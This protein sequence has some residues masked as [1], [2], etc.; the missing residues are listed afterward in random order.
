MRS[1]SI[2]SA[3]AMNIIKQVAT[4]EIAEDVSSQTYLDSMYFSGKALS[5]FA[6]IV[7][8]IHDL[9]HEPTL[10]ATGLEKLK[11]AFGKFVMNQQINPLLF[12]SK[13][14][15]IVSSGTFR[16]G[17]PNQDFGIV[18]QFPPRLPSSPAKLTSG[19]KHIL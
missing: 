1:R 17:D 16:T 15:G 11:T 14:G 3:Y 12:D 10:A 19:R 9:L 13:W 4:A 6:M 18:S 5:K 2:L 8:T 7:Y